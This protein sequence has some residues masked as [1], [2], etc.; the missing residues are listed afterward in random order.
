MNKEKSYKELESELQKL[1]SRVENA[2]YDE[3]ELL[4]ADYEQGIKLI[5]QLEKKLETAKN[6]IS[7]IKLK[8]K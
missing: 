1:L 5:K 4:L 8:E 7:K 6:K 2:D 3:L